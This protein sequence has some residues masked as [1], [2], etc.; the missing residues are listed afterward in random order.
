MLLVAAW[1][2]WAISP[3][4]VDLGGIGLSGETGS[5][6]ASLGACGLVRAEPT[7]V[8]AAAAALTGNPAMVLG[9]P[10]HAAALPWATRRPPPSVLHWD[11]G[12]LLAA[13]QFVGGYRDQATLR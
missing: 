9:A 13:G 5:L 11:Y 7:D 4:T 10:V 6:T 3:G 2:T 1:Q 8:A 12:R